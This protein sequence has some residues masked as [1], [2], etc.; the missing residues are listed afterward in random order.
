M[1]VQV[2]LPGWRHDGGGLE[3]L[4]SI[5]NAVSG[6]R[7]ASR[8]GETSDL[9]NQGL[10]LKNQESQISADTNKDL[11][12]PESPQSKIALNALI[13]T[14]TLH[15]ELGSKL[16]LS[17]ESL[18]PFDQVID[19]AKNGVVVGEQQ[20]APG[21]MGPA[22]PVRKPMSGLDA[23]NAKDSP[24][25]KGLENLY[26]VKERGDASM[27]G[28]DKH[29]AAAAAGLNMRYSEDNP[30]MDQRN[31]RMHMQNVKAI[32]SDPTLVKLNQSAD[33]LT[34]A[35]S[36]FQNGGATP[37]EFGELQQAVRANAGLKGSGGVGERQETYLKSLGIDKDKFVQFITGDP[38]SVLK[39]DPAFANQMVGLANLE[40]KNKQAQSARQLDQLAAGHKSFYAHPANAER[41]QDFQNTLD[42]SKA[43]IQAPTE[44]AQL[45]NPAAMTREQKIKFL[46]GGG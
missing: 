34:N 11:Q 36:N 24:L 10:R 9:Q 44:A 7:R 16:G 17:P 39:S 29:A 3:G 37:Q 21:E 32:N 23:I 43:R 14:A 1:P 12:D 6:M 28:A 42:Q 33:N 45:V 8:E 46:Q 35:I 30:L 4:S 41:A 15:K 26:A 22:A 38:Q 40:L 25:F 18:S 5:L 2:Q 13:G 19:S 31:E 20:M 27:Y